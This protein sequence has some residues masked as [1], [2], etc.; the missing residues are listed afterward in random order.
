MKLF[1]RAVCLIPVGAT[2]IL[3]TTGQAPRAG[4]VADGAIG[5]S[6]SMVSYSTL[7]GSPGSAK[8]P[9]SG[10]LH[11]PKGDWSKAHPDTIINYLTWDGGKWT[12]KLQG[13]GFLHAPNG[14]WS[15]AHADTIINYL[16]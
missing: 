3:L 14:D 8:L 16:T 10:F 5:H 7:N 9:G 2:V 4:Q 1:M 12:A 6:K 13:N 11:A 15:K